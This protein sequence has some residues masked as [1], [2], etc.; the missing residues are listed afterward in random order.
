MELNTD[1][2][3]SSDTRTRETT[4]NQSDSKFNW[5]VARQLE[6]HTD[7]FQLTCKDAGSD[8]QDDIIND[9]QLVD[10]T[11]LHSV[12]EVLPVLTAQVFERSGFCDSNRAQN[13]G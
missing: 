7:A 2:R 3:M 11:E 5:E 12:T 13:S 9:R 1:A 6:L 10:S 8:L 4:I